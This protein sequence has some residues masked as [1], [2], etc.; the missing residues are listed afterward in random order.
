MQKAIK[1]FDVAVIGGG[2]AGMMAARR[3]AELGARVVLLEKNPSL[4]K[5]LLMTGNGRCNL[6]NAEF[7]N[8]LFIKKLGDKKAKFLF[9]AL[10]A[11]GPEETIKFFEAKGL[12]TKIEKNQRVFPASDRAQD[13]LDVLEKYLRG[14]DVKIILNAEIVGFNLGRGKINSVKLSSEEI[15]AARFILATGGKSYPGTG[16]RGDGYAWAQTFGH[17]IVKPIPALAPVKVKETW[18]KDLQGV[19]LEQAGINIL[20]NNK[21]IKSL[22]GEIIFTHFGLSGPVI[23]N[24]SKTI[25]QLLSDGEVKI[26]ID[27]LPESNEKQLDK[28]F[29]QAFLTYA[30]KDL[31]NYLPALLSGKLS[32]VII[33]LSGMEPKKKLN[34]ITKEERNILIRLVKNLELTTIGTMGFEAA[35]VTSGGVNLSEVD[36]RTMKSKKISNLYLAGEILDLDGPTGGFNLQIA[37]S[38]GY[39]AG[40]GAAD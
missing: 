34:L 37:W 6:T 26:K 12:K 30:K 38:T 14:N 31:K 8:Q 27:L 10:A 3:A 23:I 33:K 40:A 15:Q 36:S 16:S 18:I 25:G 19:S 29:Q 13:V 4:G 5:K 1:K 32:A 2:P 22:S 35:M 11:F 20:Q 24:F 21:K 39:A 28:K 9:S 17:T 7:D